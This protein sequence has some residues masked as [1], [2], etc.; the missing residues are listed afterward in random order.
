MGLMQAEARAD[1]SAVER[2]KYL[3]AVMSCTDC[4][5]DGALIGKPDMEHFLGGS[6]IGFEIPGHGFFYGPNLTSDV[7]TGLGSWSETQIA[8][9]LTKGVRPDGR[10]LAPVMPWRSF[11]NLMSSDALA[12]AAYLKSL[13]PAK[14]KVP[15]PFGVGE[16]PMAPYLTVVVPPK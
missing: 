6:S 1:S 9:A 4:H 12:I 16:K 13:P 5:T 7:E 3:V 10:E 11:A 8:T 15:G 2:G 14:H